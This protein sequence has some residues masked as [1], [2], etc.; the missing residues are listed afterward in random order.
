MDRRSSGPTHAVLAISL[1]LNYPLPR[2]VPHRDGTIKSL[3]S[4][5][6][7]EIKLVA[8]SRESK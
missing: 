2:T 3:G 1:V 4:R 8:I 6:V 7:N 5:S